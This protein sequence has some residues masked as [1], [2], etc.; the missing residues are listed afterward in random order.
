MCRWWPIRK[1][2]FSLFSFSPFFILCVCI[3]HSCYFLSSRNAMLLSA[4]VVVV[5]VRSFQQPLIGAF[6]LFFSCLISSSCCI[7][8]RRW[9]EEEEKYDYSKSA[10]QTRHPWQHEK[11][12]DLGIG[13]H[14]TSFSSI[15]CIH[16]HFSNIFPSQAGGRKLTS[17]CCRWNFLRLK[18]PSISVCILRFNHPFRWNEMLFIVCQ[19]EWARLEGHA[20]PL[21]A[22]KQQQ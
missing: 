19:S 4:V 11:M 15:W 14:P 10:R 18:A 13:R 8:M 12:F 20:I 16:H 17:L 3:Y 2:N 9:K 1:S 22:S 5:D 21:A 7:M 6:L